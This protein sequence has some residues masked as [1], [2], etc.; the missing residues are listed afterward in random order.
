MR[1]NPASRK[2]YVEIAKNL[3]WTLMA[4]AHAATRPNWQNGFDSAVDA[5]M[6]ALKVDNSRFDRQRFLDAV[7]AVEGKMKSNPRRARKNPPS[8]VTFGNPAR[9]G[10][11]KLLSRNVVDIRY[12]H[13][14]DGEYYHHTFAR[15]QV[16]IVVDG[17]GSKVAFLRRV[18]GKPLIEDY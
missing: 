14:S 5:V 12:Q 1:N 8:L 3:R 15:N 18:D 2:L 6:S 10:N 9:M 7:Y 16:Q 13:A 17:A 4:D 11:A